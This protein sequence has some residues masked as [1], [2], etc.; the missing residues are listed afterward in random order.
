MIAVGT[1][2]AKTYSQWPGNIGDVREDKKLLK[3][4]ESKGF[5]WAQLIMDM[6]YKCGEI[7]QLALGSMRDPC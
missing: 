5:Y 4:P 2:T 6:A 3:T 7:R 1:R